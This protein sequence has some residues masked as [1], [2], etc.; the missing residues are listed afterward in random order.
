MR[1]IFGFGQNL[2]RRNQSATQAVRMMDNEGSGMMSV[3]GDQEGHH[4]TGLLVTN[5]VKIDRH[6]YTGNPNTGIFSYLGESLY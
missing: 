6:T 3:C 4:V 2:R 5:N 1:A